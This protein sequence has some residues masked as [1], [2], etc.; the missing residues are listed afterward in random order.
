MRH[1]VVALLLCV[2]LPGCPREPDAPDPLSGTPCNTLDDCNEGRTCGALT[3]CVDAR[4][5]E[6][7]YCE[8]GASLVRPCPGE[9]DPVRPP[10]P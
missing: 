6:S 1:V 2:A 9:G 10:G 7:G 4:E 8:L 5:G 3:L